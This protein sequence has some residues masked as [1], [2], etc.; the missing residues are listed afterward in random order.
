MVERRRAGTP[1]RS[2][3]RSRAASR[4]SARPSS[5][6]GSATPA[7]PRRGRPAARTPRRHRVAA[8]DARQ[9]VLHLRGRAPAR[10]SGPGTRRNG[11]PSAPGSAG[12]RRTSPAAIRPRAPARAGPPRRLDTP[13]RR[14]STASN[15]RNC[16]D[17]N[18]R[19]RV[20]PPPEARERER[21]HRL[22]DVD[23]RHDRLQDRQDPLQR[24]Q[25]GGRVPASS[26]ACSR[27]DSC[28]QL[29]EPE[30]V[31]LVDDDEQLLVVLGARR[32]AASAARAARR[33]AGTSCR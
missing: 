27:A 20:E 30:L 18:P 33:S 6:A 31:D 21:R 11:W 25:R 3:R 28:E 4:S 13:S 2:T 15:S 16:A 22:E 7:R 23:L 17:W 9:H 10:P 8:V 14:P 19:R 24:V 32:S 29:P 26:I 5:R 12:T 1:H